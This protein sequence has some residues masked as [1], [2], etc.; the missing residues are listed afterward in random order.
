MSNTAQF[1]AGVSI[2]KVSR[3]LLDFHANFMLARS[4]SEQ[5]QKDLDSGML[6]ERRGSMFRFVF[7]CMKDKS[8]PS[9]FRTQG[10][11]PCPP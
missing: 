5:W 11:I 4:A 9:H 7:D 2:Y 6:I 1:N 10:S 3:S 8:L